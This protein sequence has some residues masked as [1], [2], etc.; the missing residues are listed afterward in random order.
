[1]L[2][3]SLTAERLR[4]PAFWDDLLAEDDG[5][6][7]RR[8]RKLGAYRA[9]LESGE[10]GRTVAKYTAGTLSL[11]P[12]RRRLLNKA[13]GR[14]KVIFTFAPADEL[15]LK[16][17]N[18]ILQSTTAA[19][20]SPLCHS[21]QPGRGPRTAY[22]HVRTIPGLN[23]MCCLH[24]DVRDYFNSIPVDALLATLPAVIA[25]D[26]PL[27]RLLTATLLDNRVLIGDAEAHEP[28][29]GVMAGT[30]L[31]PLLSNL[32][33]RPL[34]DAFERAAIPYV[35]YADDIVV[36]GSRSAIEGHAHEIESRLGGLGLE[37]NHRKTRQSE[38]GE[39]W[40][41]LGLKYDRGSLDVAANTAVKLRRRA[42]RIARRARGRPDPAEYAVRKLNRRLYGVGGRWPDFTWASW[43]F[44][45]L[46][47]DATL[48][49]L[50]AT[51][52]KQLRFA[53]TGVHQRRNFRE[54]S[55]ERLR[56]VGY[57]PLVSAYHAFRGH[58]DEYEALLAGCMGRPRWA[59]DRR[60]AAP[61]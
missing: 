43:F 29:K 46:T 3:E 21:F 50:D 1:L 25:D 56:G 54:V 34:D 33:L 2:H 16:A 22:R 11:R 18:K 7:R 60:P 36:F 20:H 41:F 55:Y 61:Y 10:V 30:P 47:G 4:S 42:R 17:L 26:R 6:G 57:L 24:V 49:S 23:Q 51:I 45:L 9:L 8:W 14:K 48:R 12:P 31:A 38:P 35:R 37:L 28:H 52:Q 44:P 39:P 19:S 5:P 58:P 40:E 27:H 59:L 32:Y 53:V 13:D 15:L